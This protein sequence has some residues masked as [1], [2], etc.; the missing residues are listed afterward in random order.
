MDKVNFKGIIFDDIT[1]NED[2]SCWSQVCPKC[3]SK[4]KNKIGEYLDDHGSGA[5]GIEGCNN[6][7]FDGTVYINI[8]NFD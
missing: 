3:Q 4:Y 2:F 1:F 5:C 8:P 7:S 6:P